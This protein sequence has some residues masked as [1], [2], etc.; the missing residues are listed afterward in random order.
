LIVV[1]P[2]AQFITVAVLRIPFAVSSLKARCLIFVIPTAYLCAII[3][4][5]VPCAI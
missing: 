5:R 3:A 2:T 4:V 1:V